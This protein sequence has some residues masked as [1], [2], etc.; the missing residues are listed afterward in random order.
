MVVRYR[1]EFMHYRIECL[2]F[3][4]EKKI[5][6]FHCFRDN[7]ITIFPVPVYSSC[8]QNACDEIHNIIIIHVYCIYNLVRRRWASR[9]RT[10]YIIQRI[11]VY[12]M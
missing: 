2:L 8:A 6:Q 7:I 3:L 10:F 11:F 4:M 9:T 5:V 12:N 1:L